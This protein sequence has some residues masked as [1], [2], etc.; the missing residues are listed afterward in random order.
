[1]TK[2]I[3]RQVRPGMEAPFERSVRDI[4]QHLHDH[5]S[6]YVSTTLIR[7]AASDPTNEFTVRGRVLVRGKVSGCSVGY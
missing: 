3:R 1:M 7:P 6:G 2:I 4:S 5:Y